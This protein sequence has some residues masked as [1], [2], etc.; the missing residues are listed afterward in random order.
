MYGKA[1]RELKQIGA[2]PDD[3]L[4]R[5]NLM[6]QKDWKDPTPA[7]LLKHWDTLGASN[8]KARNPYDH[9]EFDGT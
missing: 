7:A 1:V 2:E 8:G 3:V 9:D 5:G 4:R 6:L